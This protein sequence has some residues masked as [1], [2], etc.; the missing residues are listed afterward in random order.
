[1][2]VS[3]GE[4]WLAAAGVPVAAASVAM[5]VLS[6]PG[7]AA[8]L[9]AGGVLAA[10]GG[11]LWRCTR[12][13]LSFA[14]VSAG[15]VA[16]L[17]AT[18]LLLVLPSVA[19]FPLAVYSLVGYAP[20]R[21]AVAGVA[22]GVLGAGIAATRFATDPSVTAAGWRPSL[23]LVAGLLVAV[24]LAAASLGRYRRAE[25]ALA[26]ARDR[27]R[28]RAAATAER[29]RIAREMHDVVAHSLAVI[30]SQARGGRYLVVAEP[31]RATGVLGTIEDAGRSALT[32]LRALLGVLRAPGAEDPTP[33]P[34]L[35]DLPRVLDTVRAAG[36]DV[37][38]QTSG[39]PRAVGALGELALVRA[40]QEGLTNTLR[41][42]DRPTRAT[43]ELRWD[44]DR[45]RLSVRDD[46][47]GGT[48]GEGAGLLGMRERFAAAGGAVTAGARPAGGFAVEAELPYP[49]QAATA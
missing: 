32:D 40:V 42:A 7:P 1:M 23:P 39:E 30:V 19:A 46:G 27:S 2:R 26:D 28:R 49:D 34:A 37:T 24:V 29:T 35:A 11:L 14:V 41:H 16:Q 20:R 38:Y 21:A 45:V 48:A 9:L 3:R 43:V 36:L 8:A 15:F 17:A 47:R 6:L 44:P 33:A 13:V 18:G 31:D 25:R 10:H 12:P 5:A 22:A 4:T